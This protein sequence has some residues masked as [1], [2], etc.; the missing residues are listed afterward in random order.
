M[1]L[2][3]TPPP[4][5]RQWSQEC[6][7]FSPSC[8]VPV[9]VTRVQSV[10]R[11]I[12][13]ESRAEGVGERASGLMPFLPASRDKESACHEVE[14]GEK[15]NEIDWQLLTSAGAAAR[16]GR[17]MFSCFSPDVC[18]LLLRKAGRLFPPSRHGSKRG[19][20]GFL[21]SPRSRCISV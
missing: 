16:Y 11:G 10:L 7:R 13:C 1:E 2:L 9:F 17:F 19:R 20:K 15:K 3:S 4:A 8:L 14:R 5:A 21:L 6:E 12:R 18:L